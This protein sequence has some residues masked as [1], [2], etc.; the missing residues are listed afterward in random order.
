MAIIMLLLC[1]P[2][3]L[4]QLPGDDGPCGSAAEC[5]VIQTLFFEACGPN[6]NGTIQRRVQKTLSGYVAQTTSKNATV[7]M[8]LQEHVES[9]R[10]RVSEARPMDTWDPLYASIFNHTAELTIQ[11]TNLTNGDGKTSGVQVVESGA[12]SCAVAIAHEHSHVVDGFIARGMREMMDGHDAPKACP[13]ARLSAGLRMP[14]GHVK[15]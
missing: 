12:T 1:I 5:H 10:K 13:F 7:G 4:A 15:L 8:L 14:T 9:M 6:N 3:V 2:E 11:V